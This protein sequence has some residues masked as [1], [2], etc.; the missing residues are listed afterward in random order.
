[1]NSFFFFWL[2]VGS[3]CLG[4]QL[5]FTEEDGRT[6][7]VTRGCPQHLAS[8]ASL[9]LFVAVPSARENFRRRQWVRATWCSSTI[10]SHQVSVAISFFVG[11]QS[12]I[13]KEQIYGDVVVSPYSDTVDNVTAKQ[14]YT[15]TYFAGLDA[16]HYLRVEDD[17]YVNLPM[18]T[19]EIVA[20]KARTFP[21]P[22][23]ALTDEAFCWAFFVDQGTGSA[24]YPAG[25]T[26]VLSANLVRA[27]AAANALAPLDVGRP[28]P[29]IDDED[30]GISRGKGGYHDFG[31]STDDAF[32]G[33]LLRPFRYER[34]NDRRFHDALGSSGVNPFPASQNH[35]LAVHGLR[36][37]REFHML[38]TGDFD[39]FNHFNSDEDQLLQKMDDGTSRILMQVDGTPRA[40]EIRGCDEIR[41]QSRQVCSTFFL[42]RDACAAIE[43][44]F[45]SVCPLAAAHAA[46][47]SSAAA[48][49]TK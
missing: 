8:R 5:V 13:G 49:F 46:A 3:T 1:M 14:V 30:R 34:I 29:L 41:L 45:L 26:F 9:R 23:K 40:V 6:F 35:S 4:T 7:V 36:T 20:G 44:H 19:A 18:L 21:G 27:I 32:V 48:S 31:W 39:S 12:D 47:V 38:H 28:G 17:V 42:D 33:I 2:G 10:Q 24:V 37:W 16:T 15:F 43:A 11:G 22:P 25:A